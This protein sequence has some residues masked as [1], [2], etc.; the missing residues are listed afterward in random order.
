MFELKVAYTK[1]LATECFEFRK[2]IFVDDF[3]YFK[4]DSNLLSDE[5]D[6]LPNTFNVVSI[7]DNEIIG[8]VRLMIGGG[9]N[10]PTPTD[11]YFNFSDIIG[12]SLFLSGSMFCSKPLSN[13]SSWLILYI[14]LFAAT[15]SVDYVVG[16]AN[17][18]VEHLFNK[19]GFK[20]V[21]PAFNCK[22]FPQPILPMCVPRKLFISKLR[23]II[24]LADSQLTNKSCIIFNSNEL[25]KLNAYEKSAYKNAYKSIVPYKL[26]RK[27]DDG[28]KI[29]DGFYD[30]AERRKMNIYQKGDIIKRLYFI[31]LN[32]KEHE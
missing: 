5:Y 11:K 20:R 10:N 9:K 4:N 3:N 21:R 28:R 16:C 18:K 2:K 31:G 30:G 19:F 8:S 12:N 27:F 17:P 7:K 32:H 22:D 29:K 13:V 15:Y 23:R 26:D 6:T 14:Y 25:D 24:E 1:K